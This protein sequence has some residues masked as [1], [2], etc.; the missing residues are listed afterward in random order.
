MLFPCSVRQISLCVCVCVCEATD[1]GEHVDFCVWSLTWLE[2][3]DPSLPLCLLLRSH[4]LELQQVLYSKVSSGL[5]IPNGS[6]SILIFSAVNG[7]SCSSHLSVRLFAYTLTCKNSLGMPGSP[8]KGPIQWWG[9]G[10]GATAGYGQR[11][12]G[13]FHTQRDRVEHHSALI[14]AL[15]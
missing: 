8:H 14:A 6:W 1:S 3:W 12:K 4:P 5:E 2:E 9:R 11:R 15:G 10:G 7:L 13:N